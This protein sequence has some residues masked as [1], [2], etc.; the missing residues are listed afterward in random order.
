MC[1]QAQERERSR[2]LNRA[3]PGVE[4]KVSRVGA[5]ERRGCRRGALIKCIKNL[6]A[7]GVGAETIN[8]AVRAI[9]RQRTE[10]GGGTPYLRD[11]VGIGHVTTSGSG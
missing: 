10:G 9:L 2:V 1:K 6:H 4:S 7:E 5:A 8:C 3:A 11:L